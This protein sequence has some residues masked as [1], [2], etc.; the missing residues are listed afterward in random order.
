MFMILLLRYLLHSSFCDN[1][2][3]QFVQPPAKNPSSSVSNFSI[4]DDERVK[5]EGDGISQLSL[6]CAEILKDCHR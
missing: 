6:I 3:K 1:H 5:L 2:S 4:V